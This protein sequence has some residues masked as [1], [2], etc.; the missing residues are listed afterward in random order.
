[1]IYIKEN[2]HGS[3]DGKRGREGGR[4]EGRVRNEENEN[5]KEV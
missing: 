2:N 1:M 4:K 5:I 3:M